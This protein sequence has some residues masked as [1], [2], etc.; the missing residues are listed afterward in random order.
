MPTVVHFHYKYNDIPPQLRYGFPALGSGQKQAGSLFASHRAPCPQGLGSQGLCF[1]TQPLMVL[2]LS[3]KP[4]R[5]VHL[6]NPLLRMAHCVLGPQGDGSQGL[7]GRRHG[8]DGGLPSYSG[9]QKQSGEP[10]TIRQ[11]EFGP[12]GFG[13][14]LSPSGTENRNR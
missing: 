1:F 10:L 3:R 11:P 2:G 9:R 4:G 8:F 13:S 12:H 5:H 6:A 14:H 7:D